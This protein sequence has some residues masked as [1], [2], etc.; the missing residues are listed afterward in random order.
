MNVEV[1]SQRNSSVFDSYHSSKLKAWAVV[2]SAA[3]LFLYEFIVQNMMNSISLHVMHAFNINAFQLGLMSS[4]YFV[5]N[6]I[7]LFLAGVLLD[8]FAT[9]KLILTALGICALGTSIFAVAGSLWM[10]IVARFLMGI[11]SA[12]CFLSVIRLASRW[13]PPR[14]MALVTGVIVT[15]AMTGGMLAQTPMTWLVNSMTWREAVMVVAMLGAVF[16]I[17]IY[18]LVE[19]YPADHHE[20]HTKE[21]AFIEQIGYLES[22]KMAYGHWRNW[23]GGI[24]SGLMNLPVGILGGLWGTIYLMHVHSLTHTQAAT[25]S[26]MLFVG[27]IIGAPLAGWMSD[28]IGQRRPLMFVGAVIS[29]LVMLTILFSSHLSITVWMIL[30]FILGLVTSTQVI[31][32]AL[33]AESSERVLTATSVSTVNISTQ[34]GNLLMQPVFGFLMDLHQ[35][36]RLGHT[37]HHFIPSD[38]SWGIWLFPIAFALAYLSVLLLRETYCCPRR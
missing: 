25:I 2:I 16:F 29:L 11:G 33:V 17:I 10:G 13:F 4:F 35:W 14:R 34:T 23:M 1:S 19:D 30:F 8:R 3:L 24:Y 5:S 15:M 32:Y 36:Y 28:R 6:V 31:S 38:F 37:S 21:Q 12:F 27:A 26:M 18:C 9:R 7:F 22:M 20:Q